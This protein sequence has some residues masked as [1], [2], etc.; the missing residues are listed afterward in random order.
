M[1]VLVYCL[2]AEALKGAGLAASALHGEGI[3]RLYNIKKRPSSKPLAICLASH[4]DIS[5]YANCDGLPKGILQALLPGPVTVVL[6]R[7][8]DSQLS[9]HL[10]PGVKSIGEL[11]VAHCSKPQ[12]YAEFEA[13]IILLQKKKRGMRC[14]KSLA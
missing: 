5:K 13:G 2:Y 1:K 14:S 11:L 10:N 7:R 6:M 9:D 3:R 8:P 4:S 12:R